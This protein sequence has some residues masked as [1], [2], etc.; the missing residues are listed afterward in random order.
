MLKG[1]TTLTVPAEENHLQ[2]WDMLF[3]DNILNG[4]PE[5]DESD[6]FHPN[7]SNLADSSRITLT[8][9]VPTA[10]RKWKMPDVILTTKRSILS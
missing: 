5:S 4:I 1:K 7:T 2:G 10:P 3:Y 9:F 6:F 8:E